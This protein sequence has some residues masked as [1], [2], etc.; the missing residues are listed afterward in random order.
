MHVV[1]GPIVTRNGGFAF[2]SWTP[3]HGLS[4]GYSYRRI[5][6]AHYARKMEIRSGAGSVAGPMVACSTLDEFTS[7]LAKDAGTEG[8]RPHP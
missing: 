8:A 4:R 5:E 7:V 2:D 1:V 3:G 6:D